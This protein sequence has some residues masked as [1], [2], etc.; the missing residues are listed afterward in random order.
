VDAPN[1]GSA[2][3]AESE[4]AKE[5]THKSLPINFSTFVDGARFTAEISRQVYRD[6]LPGLSVERGHDERPM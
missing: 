5:K 1:L 6:I 3:T 2:S 4:K